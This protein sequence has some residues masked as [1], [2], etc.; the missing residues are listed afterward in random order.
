MT[1]KSRSYEYPSLI[2][3]IFGKLV[4]KEQTLSKRQRKAWIC[5]CECGNSVV[6]ET[7]QLIKGN[8]ITCGC[9]R[10]KPGNLIG[11][12]FGKL[13]VIEKRGP[14]WVCKCSCGNITKPHTTQ[15]LLNNEVKSCGCLVEEFW[16]AYRLL[17]GKNPDESLQKVSAQ[18]RDKARK[19]YPSILKRDRYKCI[20]CE[21]NDKLNI[22]HII[23]ISQ[24]EDLVSEHTNL[25]TLCET[26]HE[27]CHT[28]NWKDVNITLQHILQ[29]YIGAYYVLQQSEEL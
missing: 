24:N 28:S 23:P 22:H 3:K 9:L 11:Q 5:S 19:E 16:K 1:K 12:S 15:I 13:T 7:S 6:L 2:G 17:K 14:K 18:L 4:V 29:H 26:C 21:L 20:L 10:R 25:I 27:T 8:N